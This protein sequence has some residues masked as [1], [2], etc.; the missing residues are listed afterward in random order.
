MIVEKQDNMIDETKLD[1]FESIVFID[2]LKDELQRHKD[3]HH[4]CVWI[5]YLYHHVPVK[6]KFYT[7]GAIRH[8]QDIEMIEK[9]INYLIKKW[10]LI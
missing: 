9:S 1:K 7:L 5:A 4:E 3:T 6:E 2:C 8:L 10:K